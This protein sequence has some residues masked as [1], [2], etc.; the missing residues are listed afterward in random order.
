[1]TFTTALTTICYKDRAFKKMVDLFEACERGEETFDY[2][3]GNDKP[4]KVN[5]DMCVE[6][7]RNITRVQTKS[8]YNR[9]K[10][11]WYIYNDKFM[12]FDTHST[13]YSIVYRDMPL[14]PKSQLQ[15]IIAEVVAEDMDSTKPPTLKDMNNTKPYY[16]PGLI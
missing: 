1:M 6:L 16:P 7:I 3:F 4:E 11:L 10:A 12:W 5:W 15:D 9:T 8:E 13:M 14:P 2:N